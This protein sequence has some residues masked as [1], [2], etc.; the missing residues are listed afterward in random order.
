MTGGTSPYDIVWNDGSPHAINNYVSGTNITVG[1]YPGGNTNITLTSAVDDRGC[2]AVS[3][4][5]PITITVGST[6]T[7]AILSGSDACLG[8]T[9][10][11]TVTIANGVGPYDLIINGTA[12]N[13]H[14]SGTSINLGPL[15][16][17]PHTYNLT[18]VIDDCGNPVPPGGLPGPF[19]ITIYP[20]PDASATNNNTPAICSDGTTDIVLQSTVASS[21]FIWTVSNAPAVTWVVGKAPVGGTRVNGIGTSIA[22]NLQHTATYATTVTYTITPRGPGATACLGTAITRTVI[23]NPTAQVAKPANQTVCNGTA[24]AAVNFTTVNTDGT[25]TY[26]WTNNRPSIGLPASGNGNIASFIA[27]NAG[28]VQ[29]TATIVITPTYSNGGVNCTGP[30][31]SFVINVNPEPIL[32]DLNTPTCSDSPTGVNL[33]AAPGSVAATLFDITAINFN[34]LTASG[35]SPATGNNLSSNVISDDQY[36]NKTGADVNVTYTVVPKSAAGCI[37]DAKDVVI[38]VRPEP[39]LANLN[40]TICSDVQTGITLSVAAGSS[41]ASTYNITNI[42]S[43]GLTPSAGTPT[44]PANGVTSSEIFD[45]AWTNTT[46]APVNVIY[47]VQPVGTNLCPGDVYTITLTVNP[48]PVLADL[49][50]TVCSDVVTNLNL[51]VAGG[52]FP[53]ST[54][55]I[56]TITNNGLTVAVL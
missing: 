43:N 49:S 21:D 13:N 30:I 12:Y 5:T 39:V 42:Q 47:S 54:Y 11:L 6:P 17:G 56:T 4:G 1:P 25:T 24:T 15:A 46:N 44:F 36:T 18:S 22:Q 3:L 7:G 2:P 31:Q 45:D 14:V 48:E 50:T 53:A 38:T 20:I 27:N 26:S 10:S 51:S 32:A 16:L 29:V 9:S 23:V 55:N 28:S 19:T 34:G 33:A 37:G 40:K 41:P 8:A 52:S 35:G